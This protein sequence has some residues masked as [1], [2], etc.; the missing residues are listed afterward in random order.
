[1]TGASRFDAHNGALRL[2]TAALQAMAHL[3]SDAQEADPTAL[4]ELRS[5]GILVDGALHPRLV[6][7]ARCVAV[8]LVRLTVHHAG[9]PGWSVE[10]WIDHKIAVL[11]RVSGVDPDGVA[12]VVAVPSGMVPLNLAKVVDLG[13]RERVKVDGPVTFDEGLFEALMGSDDSWGPDAIEALLD[14]GDEVLPQW[15]EV[16]AALSN[17]PSRR[18]RM[19]AWWNSAAESPAARLLEVVESD[20]GSFLLTH[21]RDPDRR[22][23]QV[24]LHPLTATQIWRLLCA[25]VPPAE[26]VDRPLSD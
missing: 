8:P 25:F 26:Q 1:M 9:A 11:L 10:G 20:I 19:G 4:D 17:R 13:P 6:P 15:V 7:L 3:A 21:R 2:S 18:W 24:R 22:Y 16:L 5:G 12:D 14:E 23:R